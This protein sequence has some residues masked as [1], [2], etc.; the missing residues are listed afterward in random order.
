MRVRVQKQAHQKELLGKRHHD[1][2]ESHNP[3]QSYIC[4]YKY[5]W[6]YSP[7]QP[8]ISSI[9]SICIWSS[10]DQQAEYV[11]WTCLLSRSSQE[12]VFIELEKIVAIGVL[13]DFSCE[14]HNQPV[15]KSS[16]DIVY[17]IIVCILLKVDDFE[18]TDSLLKHNDSDDND[19]KNEG[20]TTRRFQL[21]YNSSP[22]SS[23]KKFQRRKCT[24]EKTKGKN[25]WNIFHRRWYY[26][27]GSHH[28]KWEGL[29]L[30]YQNLSLGKSFK[31][32][33][34]S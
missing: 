33:D 15:N 11:L 4:S 28:F 7:C 18:D 12:A 31:A 13:H 30:P 25:C 8:L 24:W 27:F 16:C 5:H 20:N 21:D 2:S 9:S 29:R 14:F 34:I 26:K 3:V 17:D 23:E 22:G 10:K 19:G 6:P 1:P 32:W